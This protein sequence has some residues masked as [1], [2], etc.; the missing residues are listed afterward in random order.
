[1]VRSRASAPAPGSQARTRNPRARKYAVQPP[2]ITP[3]PTQA[4]VWTASGL[5]GAEPSSIT[6]STSGAAAARM[7]RA[8][9]GVATSAPIA[10]M[11]VTA[12]STSAALVTGF[13]RP[14]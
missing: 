9:S 5:D 1:M 8:S 12:F 2:P 4:T 11:M 14:R 10:R 7:S 13:R 3:A 6:L